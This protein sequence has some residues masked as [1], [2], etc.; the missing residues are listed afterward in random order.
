MMLTTV[1]LTSIE[2]VQK[3]KV[4]LKVQHG[5]NFMK[6]ILSYIQTLMPGVYETYFQS[7]KQ[8]YN[9]KCRFVCSFV[10]L[11]VRQQNPST[12]WNHH[13]WSFI[14]HDSSFI[15]H[16]PLSLFIHPSFISRLLSFSACYINRWFLNK[17]RT[18]KIFLKNS[19]QIFNFGIMH[20]FWNKWFIVCKYET[21]F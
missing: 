15:L 7:W 2:T 10:H 17:T 9:H 1:M 20:Q 21:P 13:P 14:L 6:F 11:F 19:Y 16:Q 5:V 8:L 12:A 4:L 18:C 3:L